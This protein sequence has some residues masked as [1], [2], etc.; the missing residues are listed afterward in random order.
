MTELTGIGP[1]SGV[2][3]F[4]RIQTR[5]LR[6]PLQTQ[7]TLKR[8]L[9]RMR[10]HMNLKT[11]HKVQQT[12]PLLFLPE[13][14]LQIG[15]PTKRHLTLRTLIRFCVRMRFHV[16]VVA[17]C[18]WQNSP[19]HLT[20]LCFSLRYSHMFAVWGAGARCW[21]V[22]I[23]RF[24]LVVAIVAKGARR[25]RWIHFHCFRLHC[26]LESVRKLKN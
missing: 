2:H 15:F 1:F 24:Q 25:H 3:T 5:L 13:N 26:V 9:S 16:H 10:T 21:P 14:N 7:R 4:M 17:R 20:H 11:K 8:S 19:T 22:E 12:N 18:R 23:Q 6:E